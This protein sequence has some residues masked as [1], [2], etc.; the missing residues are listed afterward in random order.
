MRSTMFLSGLAVAGLIAAAIPASAETVN[1]TAT[2]SPSSEVPPVTN[3]QG[4]GQ[5][6]ATYDTDTKV[7]T[8]TATYSGLTGSATMAH[9]HGPAPVGKA[10]GVMVPINGDLSSPIKGTATLTD[11]QAKALTDGQMYFNIHTPTNKGGEMRGQV[12]KAN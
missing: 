11:A 2:I 12:V 7:L 9:F 10:A 3:S 1:Y 6:A 4:M 8:Y 5:L